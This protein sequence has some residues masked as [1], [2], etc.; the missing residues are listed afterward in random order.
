M[1]CSTIEINCGTS[2]LWLRY[3]GSVFQVTSFQI[4]RP[5]LLWWSITRVAV[6]SYSEFLCLKCF[7][8]SR[9]S[10]PRVVTALIYWQVAKFVKLN[11]MFFNNGIVHFHQKRVFTT[12]GFAVIC[13]KCTH[14]H[15]RMVSRWWS[16]PRISQFTTMVIV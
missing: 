5:V 3:I 7:N 10:G 12:T 9:Y 6:R 14:F 4:W 13:F 8:V 16:W 11:V 2:E 1:S 15:S